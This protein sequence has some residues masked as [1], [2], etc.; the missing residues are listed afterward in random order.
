M[1][2][3]HR[4]IQHRSALSWVEA[5]TLASDRAFPRH[6]HDQ[7][8]VGIMVSGAH[9]SWSGIGNVEAHAGDIIMVN[10]GEMHDGMPLGGSGREWR[11]LYFDP[12]IVTRLVEGEGVTG[13][14]IVRPAVSDRL[15]ARRFAALFAGVIDRAP[16]LLLLEENLLRLIMRISRC[17]GLRPPR[18]R[19]TSPPVKK[20]LA[21]L[22]GD[23]ASPI[24]L[25]ELAQL[26]GISRFQLLRAFVREVGATPHAYL[27]QRRVYLARRLL[28]AGQPIVEA[29]IDA[30]FADQSHLTR[31]FVR[32]FGV[33]PGRYVAARA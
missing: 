32:Q 6:S 23:A 16:D 9:R 5:R 22:D 25:T 33:T 21:R 30:G 15:L 27:V 17:H 31:A 10:P 11:M 2:G 8:G 7:L 19:E 18:G 24:R 1:S 13:I 28:A 20:A 14:E 26:A 29:A 3:Q 12:S 4:M